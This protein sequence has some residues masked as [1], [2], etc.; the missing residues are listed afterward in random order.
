MTVIRKLNAI[1]GF[2][3]NSKPFDAQEELLILH[4]F[5]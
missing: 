5:L 4:F 2:G 1:D 3:I